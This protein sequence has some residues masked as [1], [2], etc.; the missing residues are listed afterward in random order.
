MLHTLK[1]LENGIGGSVFQ[2]KDSI[3][4]HSSNGSDFMWLM[5]ISDNMS[6]EQV[7]DEFT[8]NLETYINYRE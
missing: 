6:K 7:L 5:K 4:F 8:R 1:T 2:E 3:I